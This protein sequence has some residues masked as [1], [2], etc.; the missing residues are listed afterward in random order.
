M[1]VDKNGLA[2]Y[3]WIFQGSED[4]GEQRLSTATTVAIHKD[5]LSFL[6]NELKVCDPDTTMVITHHSPSY[7]SSPKRFI[8]DKLTPFFHSSLENLI[9]DY[10]PKFWIHGHIHDAVDYHIDNTR[11]IC[12]PLGYNNPFYA[13]PENVDWNPFLVVSL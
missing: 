6:E 1:S 13:T 2:D 9:L 5:H 12:N 11:I 3:N 10:Q 8:G 4:G 7:Q